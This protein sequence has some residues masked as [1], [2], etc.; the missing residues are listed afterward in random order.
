MAPSA[1]VDES[2]YDGSCAYLVVDIGPCIAGKKRMIPAGVVEGVDVTIRT[3]FVGLSRTVVEQ[4]P[5]FEERHRHT[6]DEHQRY[7]EAHCRED[8]GS[9]NQLE[10]TKP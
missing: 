1:A 6:R 8:I 7:F 2:S 3:V 5:D 9:P 10:G 4:A